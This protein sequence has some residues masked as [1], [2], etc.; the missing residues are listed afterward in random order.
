MTEETFF[1]K[2]MK[3]AVPVA[4][5]AMLQ[6]S[7]SIVDQLMVGQLGKTAIAAV[8]V[9]GKPGFIFT[10]VSGAVATV[11]GI[12]VSQ[13]MGKEDK[14]K[15]G[16]SMS[17][18]LLVME[19]IALLTTILCLLMPGVLTGIFTKDLSVVSAGAEYVRI[20]A[21]AYPLAGI[22]TILAVQIRCENHADYPLY[23]SVVAT[24]LNTALNYCLIFGHFFAPALGI[25]G[26]AI[27]S[28]V[29][30]LV[31]FILMLVAYAK[32]CSFH[33]SIRMTGQEVGQ[34]AAMLLPIVL[35]EFLW[36][37]GQTINTFIYGHMGTNELAGMSLTGPIQGLFMGALSGISQA[38]GILIGKRLGEREYDKAYKESKTLCIYG[39]LGSLVLSVI[40]VLT[41]RLYAGLF[42][43][44]ADV[45]SIGYLLLVA[46][47]ILAP[48]KV[49]NMVLGGG[50]IRSGGRT[51][52]IMIIDILGTWLVGVPLGL[53]A[54]LYLK[55]PIVWTYFLLSQEEV[56]RFIITVFMFR[57]KKWM[58]TIE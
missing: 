11:T 5:Q 45:Q 38:A 40:L 8:E 4:L 31:N 44:E 39:L 29:S 20:V 14:E 9:G 13:Y 3:I 6:S 12:M 52:Y 25:K 16:I 19:V 10:F 26:A 23:I 54:G 1:K 21:L 30:Q 48:V 43:V 49:Q 53:F 33:F 17:V 35:N 47:A 58:N 7:F 36:T 15:V 2:S 51:K 28:V 37:I 50:I 27:A 41:G 56:V 24:L 55:L 57:S 42:N 22:A 32:T 18:N 46:F 34:Y